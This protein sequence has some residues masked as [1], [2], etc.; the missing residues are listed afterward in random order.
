[1]NEV[2]TQIYEFGEFRLDAA[3]R[4]LIKGK[5]EVVSLTPKVFDTLLYLVR[6][7]GK[8]IEKDE[9]MREIW[10]DSI[11][12][13]NNL[14]QNISILRR[15]FGEK[16]G[17]Q[18]FIITV[19]G[20]GYR[21]VPE[22]R[23]VSEVSSSG[24]KVS[25]AVE[26]EI[27]HSE[28]QS[29]SAAQISEDKLQNENKSGN[30]ILRLQNESENNGESEIDKFQNTEFQNKNPK[31]ENPEPKTKNR[32]S[33][34]ALTVLV[35]SAIGAAGFY[36][37]RENEKSIDAPIKT[38]AVLPFKPLTAE[39]RNEALELGM[40]DTLISKL[41]SGEKVIV[42]PLGSVRR[43]NSLE[44]DSLLAGRELT[45]DS[46]LE[47]TIQTAGNRIRISARLL[48]TLDGK[49]LWSAQFDEKFTDIFDVQDSIS[50]RAAAAL[51]FRLGDKRKK[52][53]TENVEAYQFY[54]KGRFHV[55]KATRVG[56]E[57]GILNLAQAI[58][59][60][61][62][63][64][65]AY[66]GLADAYRAMSLAGEIP[67]NEFLPKAKAAALKAIEIDDTLAEAHAVLGSIIFWYEWDWNAAENHYKRALVLDPQSADARQFYAHLL[68]NTGQHAEALS[69]IKLA[70]EIDPLNLRTGALE[71]LFL[72]HAGQPDEALGK[73]RKT[74]ELDPNFWLANNFIVRVFIQKEM[75]AEAIAFAGKAR[76][77]SPASS[78]P[79]TASGYALA[80]SGKIAE[81][82]AVLEELQKL[83]ATRHVPPYNIALVYNALGES[84]KALDYLKKGFAEKDVRMVFLKVEPKWNNLRNE[85]RFI[86]LMRRMN[87][88]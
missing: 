38:V 45:V 6:H 86:D 66:V 24:F 53:D 34:I 69:E 85:P 75:Y 4:L 65:L 47:G 21:F 52:R 22:V 77:I 10:T 7:G 83:S 61:P 36:L 1:M 15:I 87:F 50:E 46:V 3:K 44:Q 26:S 20:H 72:L 23:E 80:K 12:E 25:G 82:R 76:E 78:E 39:N 43:Y 42:R 28:L 74:L 62:N 88:E 27:S 5:G 16:P 64:A 33:Y 70:R 67:S 35:I 32:F 84:D 56:I 2:Q 41:S 19:P 59:L 9:L 63:Y 73:L 40:A 14:N 30:S 18:R 37:W 29:E 11:V 31:L 71:G 57:T 79:V 81:A 51:K 60:D 48:R 58:E 49:Q 8:V 13:E 54:A 55:L 68:S 17:E